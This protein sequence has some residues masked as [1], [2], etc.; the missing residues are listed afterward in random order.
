MPEIIA[1]PGG[2]E[3]TPNSMVSL[4]EFVAHLDAHA[5]PVDEPEPE[6]ARALL[7]AQRGID[8][9][10]LA[11]KRTESDQPLSFPRTGLRDLDYRAVASDEIPERAKRSQMEW[12]LLLLQGIGDPAEEQT[13]DEV[14][15]GPIRVVQSSRSGADS[16]P[17][18][19]DGVPSIV[20]QQLG[21]WY[22]AGRIRMVRS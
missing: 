7:T 18:R 1:W 5:F 6:M 8:A 12:A 16:G 20:R 10:S 13:A 14:Q 3:E 2:E 15:V 17:R 4:A 21:D 11:G 9:L 22:E 19:R